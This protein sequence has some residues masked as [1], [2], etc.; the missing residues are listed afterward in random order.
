MQLEKNINSLLGKVDSFILDMITDSSKVEPHVLVGELTWNRFDL[1]IKINYLEYICGK[2]NNFFSQAYIEHIKA[3]SLGDFNERGNENKNSISSFTLAFNKL[4]TD[5]IDN[6][7]DP[8]KSYIPLAKDGSILNGAHRVAIS[9]FLKTPITA[10]STDI[11][12]FIYDYNFFKKRGVSEAIL[13]SAA[14]KYA[15]R[16]SKCYLAFLWPSSKKSNT[17]S[18]ESYFKKIVY[19]K[20]INLNYN[21]AHNLLSIAYAGEEWLGDINENYPGVKNKLVKCFPNFGDVKVFLFEEDNLDIVLTLKDEIRQNFSLGKHSIHIT[22]TKAEVL[23]LSNLVFNDNGLNFLN[24]AYPNKLK[25]AQVNI[26]R[27]KKFI[28]NNSLNLEEYVLDSGMVLALYGLR[29]ASDIDYIT[30][31]NNKP[32]ILSDI[33]ED[34]T[35]YVSYH[36]KNSVDLV[37]DPT[38]YFQYKDVK[39]ISLPQIKLMKMNRNENKDKAD[40]TLINSIDCVSE[41]Q[42]R[43]NGIKYKFLFTKAK[44]FTSV[45]ILLINILTGLGIYSNVR[46]VYQNIKRKN[47]NG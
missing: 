6:G 30:T 12:P 41:L 20:S 34:H 45:K 28:N 33:I 19:S 22:D 32:I 7:F 43:I 23:E 29:E 14:I 31:S 4:F 13:D 47:S 38:L 21:G 1:A 46:K 44:L 15:E 40:L 36:N 24:N 37:F 26:D 27:F 16:V 25:S 3:F 18:V 11:E 17:F 35:N 8:E 10:I 42:V 2:K 5:M 9:N 39:F